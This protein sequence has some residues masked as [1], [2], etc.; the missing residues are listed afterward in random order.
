M[1]PA[2]IDALFD[3]DAERDRRALAWA[4]IAALYLLG[5]LTWAYFLGWRPGAAP[6]PLNFHDWAD[7]NVPR[8]AFL[9]NAIA[10]GEWP[11]HMAYAH[12]LH[13][14][15]DRFLTLPDVITTPQTLLLPWLGVPRFIRLD[16]LL[17]YSAGV[18]GLLAIR[19]RLRWSLF[20]YGV[21]FILF[22]FNGH[23]LSHYSVG[24][25][26]WGSYFLFPWFILFCMQLIDGEVGWRWV[27]RMAFLL[28]YM[29]LA[30]G[31]H[32]FTWAMLFLGC[33]I[34][35]CFDRARWIVA[36]GL[37]AGLLSAVRL[38]PPVLSLDAF[39]NAGWIN[40]I[41]G[42]PSIQ[43]LVTS[44]VELR[45]EQ[46]DVVASVL[47]GN[48]LFFESNYFEFAY[49]IGTI[50]FAIV[51]YFGIVEWLRAPEP[52]YPQL[53]VP[54]LVMVMLSIGS[55]YR[56][57]RATGIPLLMSERLVSR[58][59]S[60]PMSVFMIMAGVFLQRGLERA[61]LSRWQRG[62][63]LGVW[64]LLAI[65]MSGEVRLMRVSE[66]A[67]T[68]K[69]FQLDDSIGAITRRDDPVYERT[70]AAGAGLSILTGAGLIVLALR[71]GHTGRSVN[72]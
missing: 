39:A 7:I 21:V 48:F 43:H 41:I 2:A 18:A 65:D 26:T 64:L 53:I 22:L 6:V 71:Q 45:R 5:A 4:W 16:V 51:V 58:M 13:G 49:Y 17:H 35:C 56:I 63:A 36:A 23:V 19:A 1:V 55:I 60:L 67:Q 72:S 37:A 40:D 3:I 68:T 66:T 38:L 50:G 52:R 11:L 47:P 9:S 14:V 62:A 70:V 31:Q 57:V 34:P 30:G 12:S 42:Y 69:A 61:G 54:T 46:F 29:V 10:S 33:L 24:H 28:C 44:L 32:H 8:L 27:A 59:L 25:F 15:T 20:T